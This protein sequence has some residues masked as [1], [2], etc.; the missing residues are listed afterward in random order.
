M[1]FPEDH[2]KELDQDD[3]IEILIKPRLGILSGMKQ[4]LIPT[5]KILKCIMK[6]QFH[7]S[8]ILRT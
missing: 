6:D 4:W 5:L 2:P 7:I 3:M 1:Y 8:R